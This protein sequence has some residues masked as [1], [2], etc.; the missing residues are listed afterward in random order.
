ME[1]TYQSGEEISKAVAGKTI[2]CVGTPD[3][4][5]DDYL[6]VNFTDGS[7]LHVR[8]DFVYEW[9]LEQPAG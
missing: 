9:K 3:D 7:A 2:S 5:L 8:Y 4:D 1:F 6:I